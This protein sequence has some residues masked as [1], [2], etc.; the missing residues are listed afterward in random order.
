[1][2]FDKVGYGLQDNSGLKGINKCK[3]MKQMSLLTC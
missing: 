1:M 3:G 2:L